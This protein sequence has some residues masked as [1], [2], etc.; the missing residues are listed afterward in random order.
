MTLIK[1]SSTAFY[2]C[3]GFYFIILKSIVF[4]GVYLL[5]FLLLKNN[6]LCSISAEVRGFV[7]DIMFVLHHLM[8]LQ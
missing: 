5:F 3:L 4:T 2:P 7:L 6:S 1:M 8:P